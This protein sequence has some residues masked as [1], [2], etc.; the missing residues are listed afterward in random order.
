MFQKSCETF[1]LNALGICVTTSM[2]KEQIPVYQ[3]KLQKRQA[4]KTLAVH[5]YTTLIY[6]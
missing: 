5:T 4:C 2:R 3:E 1:L 6:V